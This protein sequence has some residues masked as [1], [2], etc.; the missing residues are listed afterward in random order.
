[1]LIDLIFTSARNGACLILA[2]Y[3]RDLEKIYGRAIHTVSQNYL[4]WVLDCQILGLTIFIH[5]ITVDTI[6]VK[7]V[8]MIVLRDLL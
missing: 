5:C 2:L 4:V 7:V 8:R 3:K 1:M 6:L